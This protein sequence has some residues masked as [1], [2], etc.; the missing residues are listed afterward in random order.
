[1]VAFHAARDSDKNAMEKDL[2]H[3]QEEIALL[4]AKLA[5]QNSQEPQD[6]ILRPLNAREAVTSLLN[7]E[8]ISISDENLWRTV[9]GTMSYL[10][11]EL[12]VNSIQTIRVKEES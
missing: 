3:A 4:Q 5:H 6:E 7:G 12:E 8:S 1:M 10:E 9:Q 2:Q 11:T